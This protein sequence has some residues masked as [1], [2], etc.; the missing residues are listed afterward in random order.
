[1]II[2]FREQP[3]SFAGYES[4]L[5]RLPSGHPKI[6]FV[7]ESLTQTRA[8]FGGECR[9]DELLE[10]FCPPYPY[11]MLQGVSLP[12]KCQ[13]DTMIVTQ[14]CVI[15]LEVK[16]ISGLTRYTQQPSG[17]HK[18]LPSGE[19]RGM[20]SPLVQVENAKFKVEQLLKRLDAPLPIFTAIVVAYPSQ[21]VEGAPAGANI[22]RAEEVLVRLTTMPMPPVKISADEMVRLS[23]RLAAL[24]SEFV[25]FPLA[26]RFQV[27][28][29]E[30]LTGVFC[31]YCEMHKMKRLARSW[32]CRMC[33]R[34][35]KGLDERILDE[36]FMLVGPT[37]TTK[38]C[39]DFFELSNLESAYRLLKRKNYELHGSKKNRFYRRPANKEWR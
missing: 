23:E 14:S 39:L 3:A 31:P 30:L 26:P 2:K 29:K 25:P 16:N 5:R 37:I 36:W 8:G 12:E 17:F 27:S 35:I 1:M 19:V 9:L 28:T 13:I 24:D 21:L 7:L 34:S 6:P 18:V 33:E 15:L 22:W 11:V 20:K 38:E 10:F 4:L 32:I